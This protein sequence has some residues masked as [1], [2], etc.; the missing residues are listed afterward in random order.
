MQ[1]MGEKILICAEIEGESFYGL[2]DM[3]VWKLEWNM[4]DKRMV[5]VRK[6]LYL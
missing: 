3:C 4:R 6:T 5:R 1:F 2:G